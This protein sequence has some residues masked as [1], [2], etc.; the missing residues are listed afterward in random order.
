[1]EQGFEQFEEK[2]N[3]LQNFSHGLMGMAGG[4]V[5]IALSPFESL[6]EKDEGGEELYKKL[7][8]EELF[9]I[10]SLPYRHR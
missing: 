10:E 1:M 7:T 5:D 2:I 3:E 6:F 4:F 8:K 9:K